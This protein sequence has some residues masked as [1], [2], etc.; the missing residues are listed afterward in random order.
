MF[1]FALTIFG[2]ALI[3][4]CFLL[5]IIW[6]R[7]NGQHVV[8]TPIFLLALNEIVRVWP[9]AMYALYWGISPDLF[10]LLLLI[11]STFA[12]FG[13]YMLVSRMYRWGPASP[14]AFFRK[15][16]VVQRSTHQLRAVLLCSI[17]LFAVGYFLYLGPPPGMVGLW[18][19]VRKG[20]NGNISNHVKDD[21]LALTKGHYFG[22]T[23]RGQGVMRKAMEIGWPMLSVWSIYSWFHTRKLSWA[24]ASGFFI[25]CL[26]FYVGGDGTRGPVIWA[27]VSVICGMSSFMKIRWRTCFAYGACLLALLV[28]FSLV[29]RLTT[30][31]ENGAGMIDIAGIMAKRI[32]VGNGLNTIYTIEFHREGLV[33]SR[34]GHEHLSSLL[35]AIPGVQWD[36]P[37]AYELFTL[38]NPGVRLDITAF[39]SL[40]Y[41]GI[42]YID[43]G[44]TGCVVGMF[45][46]GA[47]AACATQIL[48]RQ[49]K[50]GLSVAMCGLVGLKLGQMNLHGPSALLSHMAM[51]FV[52]KGIYD[53]S[54]MIAKHHSRGRRRRV[55]REPVYRTKSARP[56]LQ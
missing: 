20:V 36:T 46:V 49:P 23:Y 12:M 42:L 35:N 38:V 2:A 30:R 55:R 24:W 14:Q 50:T 56:V 18:Q 48:Y 1:F 26:I 31:I 11:A 45:L 10:P 15:T 54:L 25:A 6:L 7:D 3:A 22:G 43:F 21:R 19:T 29:Q 47:I 33:H 4:F 13:G 53:A 27:L 52:F 8:L 51:V 17:P 32:F 40:T 28:L 5:R 39:A 41:V 37:F 9:A 44:P 16:A 34:G